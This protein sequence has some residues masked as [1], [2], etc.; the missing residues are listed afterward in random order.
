[1]DAIATFSA[2]GVDFLVLVEC[3]HHRNFIKR[4]LVQVLS[5]K[6]RAASAHEA[7]LLPTG[8]FQ[9]GALELAAARPIA[10]VQLTPGGPVYERKNAFESSG[11]CREYD[12]FWATLTDE[13]VSQR[14]GCYHDLADGVFGSPG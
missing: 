9:C 2:L 6:Q 1:M 13:G 4:E 3:K 7:I 8:P 5:D 12:A 10:L 14:F 11:P